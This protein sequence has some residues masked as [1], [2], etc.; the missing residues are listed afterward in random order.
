[1][2]KQKNAI[3]GVSVNIPRWMP[4][5]DSTI[6]TEL[7]IFTSKEH[8]LGELLQSAINHIRNRSPV[9]LEA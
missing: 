3:A 5:K 9:G 8:E 4:L 7:H 1:M 6:Q 2:E